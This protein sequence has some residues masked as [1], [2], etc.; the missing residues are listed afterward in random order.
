MQP[1]DSVLV[2]L[3]AD[4]ASRPIATRLARTFS[5]QPGARVRNVDPF[6][7]GE[8]R[9]PRARKAPRAASAQR[10]ELALRLRNQ[11]EQRLRPGRGMRHDY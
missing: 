7:A 6:G 2:A 9:K 4:A 1:M 10:A 8:M 11:P 3:A 5:G